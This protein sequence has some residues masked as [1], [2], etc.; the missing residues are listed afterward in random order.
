[1]KNKETIDYKK[2]C[3][4]ERDESLLN[5]RSEPIDQI[6]RKYVMKYIMYLS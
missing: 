1:M 3:F 5:F 6:I 4:P 2:R